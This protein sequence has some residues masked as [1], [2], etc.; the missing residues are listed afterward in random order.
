MSSIKFDTANEWFKKLRDQLVSSFENLRYRDNL[1]LQ[2]GII[3]H[4]GG[5]NNE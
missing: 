4:E 2:N 5:G 1:L 3:N